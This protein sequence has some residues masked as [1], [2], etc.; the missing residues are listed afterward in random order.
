VAAVDR[1]R[2]LTQVSARS[3]VARPRHQATR[4]PVG[5]AVGQQ[6][7]DFSIR[8]LDGSTV[9]LSSLR[10]RS[11]WLNVWATT[12]DAC[13]AAMPLIEQFYS[14]N[15]GSGLAVV[16][17]T[18]EP[19]GPDTVGF[20]RALGVTFTLGFD[21]DGSITRRYRAPTLPA[22]FWIDREGHSRLGARRRAA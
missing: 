16:G 20:A 6:A 13:L 5:L 3:P 4:S 10:G 8:L 19:P 12:C 14:E 21:R 22:D 7:P 1:S 2:A 15:N 11:V 9:T 18:I 17:I